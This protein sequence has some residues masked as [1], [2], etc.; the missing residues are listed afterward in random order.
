VALVTAL[1][2][3]AHERHEGA[4]RRAA[5]AYLVWKAAKHLG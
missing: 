1:D 2:G 4:N 3:W 5:E